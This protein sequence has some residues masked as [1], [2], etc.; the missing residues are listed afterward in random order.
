MESWPTSSLASERDINVKH[1]SSS[2]YKISH[3]AF[4]INSRSTRWSW[5]SRRLW[6][7]LSSTSTPETRTLWNTWPNTILDWR[8]PGQPHAESNDWGDTVR[9][10]SSDIRSSPWL[11]TRPAIISLLYQWP[12][13]LR[14]IWHPSVCRWLPALQNNT[15]STRCRHS[16][17]R[18]EH[19][20]TVG[21]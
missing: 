9:D 17:R 2:Q 13:N 6:Q 14:I 11:C 16:P 18:S 4:V 20:T 19:V 15:L 3:K 7:S 12:T 8:L 5:T 21:R 10:S 1:N